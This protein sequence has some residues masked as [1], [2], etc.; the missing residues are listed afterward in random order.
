MAICF[1][2]AAYMNSQWLASRATS[3]NNSI[4]MRQAMYTRVTALMESWSRPRSWLGRFIEVK[5][6]AK[7]KSRPACWLSS[8]FSLSHLYFFFFFS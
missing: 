3:L 1:Y 5:V 2:T 6:E 7:A 4:S 8:I